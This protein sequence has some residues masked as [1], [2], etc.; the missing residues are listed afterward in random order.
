MRSIFGN[1]YYVNAGREDHDILSRFY[2]RIENGKKGAKH[3]HII[4]TLCIFIYFFRNYFSYL[5]IL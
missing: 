2:F 5:V 4:T 3:M 1:I